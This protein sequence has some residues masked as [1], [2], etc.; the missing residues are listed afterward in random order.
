MFGTALNLLHGSWLLK[1]EFA[2]FDG[3]KYSTTGEKEF[4]RRDLLLGFEYKGIADTMIS[5]DLVHRDIGEYDQ[6]L[7]N[8]LNPL[9]KHSYQH[10]FRISTDFMH[11]TLTANYLI[12]MNGEKFDEGGFQR[13]WV[14]YELGEGINMNIGAVDYMGG[15]LGFDAIKYNDMLFVDISYSF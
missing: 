14:K 10:A 13:A 15:T 12:F 9:D 6:R 11:A 1:T 3:L 8:E 5:Y 4:T 2:Y 7:M